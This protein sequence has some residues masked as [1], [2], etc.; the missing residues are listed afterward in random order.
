M[1]QTANAVEEV[2][3][4]SSLDAMGVHDDGLPTHQLY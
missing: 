1:N 2:K 4:E 3:A